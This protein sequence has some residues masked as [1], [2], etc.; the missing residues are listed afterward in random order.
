MGKEGGIWG[1]R[2]RSEKEG[3]EGKERKEGKEGKEAGVEEG[4]RGGGAVSG[5]RDV[6]S[7]DLVRAG[8]W[9]RARATVGAGLWRLGE[10]APR[11][12]KFNDIFSVRL[13]SS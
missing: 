9:R 6:W 1:R 3:Q 13:L 10:A 7:D 5:V 11:V 12:D 2:G 8:A 4:R